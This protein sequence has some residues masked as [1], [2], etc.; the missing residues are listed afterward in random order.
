MMARPATLV[1]CQAVGMAGTVLQNEF[2]A[3][4]EKMPLCHMCKGAER[5]GTVYERLP[6]PPPLCPSL[7]L[8]ALA[9]RTSHVTLSLNLPIK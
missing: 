3:R 7:A 8:T 5:K 2:Q 9:D 1:N 4:N 6:H